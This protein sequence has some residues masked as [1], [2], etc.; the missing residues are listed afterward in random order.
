MLFAG[1]YWWSGN[2]VSGDRTTNLLN[3][4]V[5]FIILKLN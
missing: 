3:R 5:L 1:G 4:L 2:L